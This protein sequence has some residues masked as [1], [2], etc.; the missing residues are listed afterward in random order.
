MTYQANI[1]PGFFVTTEKTYHIPWRVE[2]FDLNTNELI[3]EYNLDLKNKTI[4]VVLDSSSL[5]DNITWF[6]QIERFR[7]LKN[8]KV[9][10]WTTDKYTYLWKENYPEIEFITGDFNVKAHTKY[11][12]DWNGWSH[13]SQTE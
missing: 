9:I 2:I 1:S 3:F 12:L 5:G 13:D 8:C 7:K 11:T 4:L 6:P 10:C